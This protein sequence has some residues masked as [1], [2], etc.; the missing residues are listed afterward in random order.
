MA[1]PLDKREQHPLD[2][3]R[4]QL[5]DAAPILTG[6]PM[7][8]AKVLVEGSAEREQLE[9]LPDEQLLRQA[10]RELAISVIVVARALMHQQDT[11]SDKPGELGLF[12][13][14]C[15]MRRR[16]PGCVRASDK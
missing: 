7:T 1:F 8:T 14:S 2:L 10:A 13:V 15:G 3:A 4:E 5:D 16:D 11:I 6:D 12:A 9:S